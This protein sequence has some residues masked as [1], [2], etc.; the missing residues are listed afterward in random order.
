MKFNSY[1]LICLKYC[2]CDIC[3]CA[4]THAHEIRFHAFLIICPERLGVRCAINYLCKEFTMSKCS[5][6]AKW[7][8]SLGHCIWTCLI[9]VLIN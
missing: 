7:S 5:L 1:H 3:I 9:L 4:H 2:A 8:H 6:N